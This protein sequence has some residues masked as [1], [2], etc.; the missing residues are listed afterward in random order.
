[1]CGACMKAMDKGGS[2][3]SWGRGPEAAVLPVDGL[4]EAQWLRQVA[5]LGA[6]QGTEAVWGPVVSHG[7]GVMWGPLTWV[8]QDQGV[9]R[10]KGMGG[11][12]VD[13]GPREMGG[14]AVDKSMGVLR[15]CSG[16]DGVWTRM[17]DMVGCDW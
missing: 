2:L 14:V 8:A 12:A 10:S 3:W 15:A 13:N 16:G 6:V 9:V 4:R 17:G 1:M 7:T 11:M 5:Q